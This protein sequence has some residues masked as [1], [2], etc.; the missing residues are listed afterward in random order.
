[1][2]KKNEFNAFGYPRGEREIEGARLNASP[3]GIAPASALGLLSSRALSSGWAVLIVLKMHRLA[4][5]FKN[6]HP[7]GSQKAKNSFFFIFFKI[8]PF[9][10]F[11][12]RIRKNSLHTVRFT[13]NQKDFG[14]SLLPRRAFVAFVD[15]I[16]APSADWCLTTDRDRHKK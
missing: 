3:L 9:A 4:N 12:A 2:L 14:P 8:A 16:F 10:Y 15:A 1:M 5:K 7:S 13:K 11:F 6:P